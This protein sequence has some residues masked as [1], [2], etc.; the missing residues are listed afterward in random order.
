MRKLLVLACA[1]AL[2]LIA[3]GVGLR[4]QANAQSDDY[5]YGMM[6]DYGYGMMGP[7]MM[8]P[9]DVRLRP[10]LRHDG[11][12]LRLWS[13]R[14]DARL[15]RLCSRVRPPPSLGAGLWQVRT[16]LRSRHDGSW[17]VGGG[18]G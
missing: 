15:L 18:R 3:G 13:I 16:R 7:G 11:R 8:G 5:G 6:G 12:L 9:H 14:N 17:L 1:V 10:R 2:A 4:S